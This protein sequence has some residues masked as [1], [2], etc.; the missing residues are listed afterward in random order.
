MRL[1]CKLLII[2]CLTVHVPTIS[3]TPSPKATGELLDFYSHRASYIDSRFQR[4][5][6]KAL[7]HE[8]YHHREPVPSSAATST[9][10]SDTPQNGTLEA[11][12]ASVISKHVAAPEN[13]I[14]IW[15]NQ[16][17]IACLKAMMAAHDV[18]PNPSGIAPCYNIPSFDKSTGSFT[19]NL[20]LYAVSIPSDD[21]GSAESQGMNI[22]VSF[23]G[24]KFANP[25]PRHVMRG[26]EG[27]PIAMI[28]QPRAVTTRDTIVIPRYIRDLTF[29]GKIT[30]Y[31]LGGYLD[32]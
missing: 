6:H 5:A 20:R 25:S 1:S 17:Q 14:S 7:N 30:D 12:S 26:F 18:L 10:T 31:T 22:G 23:A 2:T 29:H 19:A 28:D 21:W 27:T 3:S 11:A 9:L 8:I 24:A 15:K 32:A 13:D 16:T 4:G